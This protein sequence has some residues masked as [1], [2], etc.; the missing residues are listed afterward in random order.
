[1]P[2]GMYKKSMGMTK[3]PMMMK[4]GGMPKAGMMCKKMGS[5]GAA[6]MGMMAKGSGKKMM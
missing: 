5:M 6:P 1:M 2:K 3:S 4:K